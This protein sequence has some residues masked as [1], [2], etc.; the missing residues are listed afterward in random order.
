MLLFE[1]LAGAFADQ[2]VRDV[3]GLMG[4]GNKDWMVRLASRGVAVHQVRHEGAGLAMAD[5]YARA[6]RCVGVA[7][8][9]YGPGGTQLATSLLVAGKARTPLVV[10]AGDVAAAHRVPGD[11]LDFDAERF[12]TACEAPV[13]RVNRDRG[14]AAVAE[15]FQ[16]AVTARRPVVLLAAADVQREPA[17]AAAA[18]AGPTVRPVPVPTGTELD[19][20]AALVRGWRRPLVLAGRGAVLG[21]AVAA[22]RTIAERIGALTATTF[23]AKGALDDDPFCLGT[24]GGFAFPPRRAMFA[25]CDGVL[26]VGARLTEHTTDHGRLFAGAP[27]VTVD[28]E[29]PE[30]ATASLQGDA[31]ATLVALADRLPAGGDARGWRDA[32]VRAELA[33]DPRDVELAEPPASVPAGTVDPRRLLLR[34]D[35]LLPDP[36]TIVVGGGHCMGFPMR[37]LTGGRGRRFLP[38]FDFM[39]TGQGL[40]CSIGAALA[41]PERPVIGFEGDASFLMH[42]QELETAARLRVPLLFFVLNDEALG[43]EYHR[44]RDAGEDGDRALLSTPDLARL[45]E[46]F[47]ARGR[48]VT[49]LRQLD[50]V[51]AWFDP[52]AGPHVVDCRVAREVRGPL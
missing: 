7:A 10:F 27:I 35:A 33:Q 49:S 37:Y 11:D 17:R 19:R 28:L 1:A 26:A 23:G 30:G 8:V 38:A 51:L 20:V 44:L 15:A 16:L 45:A 36:A 24:A 50:D 12:F 40:A 5:G 42:V 47:G 14:A 32:A 39:T 34:L 18:G 29:P 41:V 52:S 21:D 2:Q 4:D 31:R 6:G 46:A 48:T 3:F 13:M 25:R 43:A 9:T 22:A